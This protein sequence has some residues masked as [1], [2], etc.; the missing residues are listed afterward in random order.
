MNDNAMA[1]ESQTP[2]TR[3]EAVTVDEQAAL[4]SAELIPVAV[5]L[6]WTWGEVRPDREIRGDA[7]CA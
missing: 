6:G 3:D 1:D 2:S 4:I 5:F 7:A